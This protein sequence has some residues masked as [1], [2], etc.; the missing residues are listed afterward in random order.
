MRKLYALFFLL[1]SSLCF[2]QTSSFVQ[3]SVEEGMVQSQ[4]QSLVQDA[5]GNLWI[6]TLAGLSRYDGNNFRNYTRKDGLA[7]DWVTTSYKDSKNDIWFGHWA[8][9][10]SRY[11][12]T[13]KKFESLNLEEYTRFRTVT[14]ITED[15]Q[16]FYWIATEGAG[17]F[18]YD[19]VKNSMYTVT[20]NEGIPS[21][22]V[23]DL[24]LDGNGNMWIATD[25]G[26]TICDTRSDVSS[27]QSYE[28]VTTQRGFPSDV[29]TC[30]ALVNGGKEIWIG[31][32]DKGVIALQLPEGFINRNIPTLLPGMRVFNSYLGTGSDF[33][34]SICPDSRGNIW[35]GTTGG[36][37]TRISPAMETNRTLALDKAVIRNYSTRQ[38]L[39][40]FN[41]KSI[42]EDREGNIWLGTDVGL[43][44]YRGELFTLYDKQDGLNNDIVWATCASK[45]GDVWLGTNEGLTRLHFFTTPGSNQRQ[46]TATNYTT[47]D[48]LGSNV[49][50][51]LHET[52]DGTLWV[53][54]GFGGMS[55]LAPG[56]TRFT[57]YTTA[58]GLAGDVVYA[59]ASDA[60]GNIWVGTKEGASRYDVVNKT[61]SN[62]TTENGLGG[63]NV[64]RIFRDSKGN[65]WFGAL[66]G[67]L[68]VF[69][70]RAFTKF[71]EKNGIIHRFILSI[72][73]D[74]EHNM[75]FGAY[76]GGLYKY[77]G[78][79]FSNY[80][81]EDGMTTESPYAI[82]ADRDNNIWI[83][84]GR[85][86]DRFNP[87]D[88]SFTHFGKNDG[89]LGVEVNPNA[90]SIDNDGKIW[91]G[92]IMGAVCFNPAENIPNKTEALT[93]ITGLR[94][95]MEDAEFPEDGIFSYNQNHITFVFNGVCLTSPDKVRYRYKLEGFDHDWSPLPTKVNEAVYTNL[96]AGDYT[97]MVKAM[98]NDGLWNKDPVKYVFT[99]KPPFW[100]T[101]TFYGLMT[102]F[103]IFCIYGFDRMRTRQLKKQ[104]RI[105][106]DKV[107]ERTQELALKN[108]E[109]A[110]KNREI[111]DSIRYAKR[112][113]DAMLLPGAEMQ[114]VLSD[115]FILYKPKDIVSGDFYFFRHTHVNGRKRYWIAA[116]DCTGHG[117]PGAF[118]SIV[119]NDMLASAIEGHEEKTPADI[120]D[121]LN[122]LMSDKM[123]HTI[124]DVRVRDGVDIALICFEP[125]KME[126]QYAGA[127]NPM[128][129][130][131][132][133]MFQEF[134]ADK[135]SIGGF[136][137]EKGKK[138]VNQNLQLQTG[139]TLYLF[140]DGYADQFGGPQG[141]KFKLTQMKAVLLSIQDQ[142]MRDQERILDQTIESWRGSLEQVDDMLVVGLRV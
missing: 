104:K 142:D 4:V 54:T 56:A 119:T 114:K 58:D 17:I 37:A 84:N 59:L 124:D 28:V 112:L 53:G 105:L 126:V 79:T 122:I 92:T 64:Y 3:Y 55:S 117:V 81:S 108:E 68:S 75:W 90:V 2:A 91:F 52:E 69:D 127:F 36:G 106:E 85:G 51:A 80:S 63:N 128:Y 94:I 49:I 14:A 43:N 25:K 41:V 86:L 61:F 39:N 70:G 46:F 113:Q 129:H 57:T 103:I 26:L 23:Y 35:I 138:Y 88:S 6:G 82:I 24:C 139:D 78:R 40:Y 115:S 110:E 120:L 73:E 111:T 134:K 136:H 96:P 125:E 141:K 97:F 71:D 7:E 98:N 101:F 33:I 67:Y 15:P 45:N 123:R 109:L 116:V 77:D 137:E 22:N 140:S 10:V 76:G 8:G 32:G 13:T 121:R 65:M 118:M 21:L 9:G 130:F 11:N 83:G 95:F 18:I 131:R 19:P 42:I 16:G 102:G 48:G 20:L 66:G 72:N 87:K 93:N 50:L 62:Y 47:A 44:K 30:F 5:N 107:E 31:T 74:Q 29:I 60:K 34:E 135:I 12:H 27:P 89:F 38:G 132:G 133:K 1:L 100:Q 99:V